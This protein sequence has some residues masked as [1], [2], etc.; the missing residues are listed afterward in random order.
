M[1]S[2]DE[3]GTVEPWQIDLTQYE[4]KDYDKEFD[5][6]QDVAPTEYLDSVI[7][8]RRNLIAELKKCYGLIDELLSG[9][10]LHHTVLEN[11]DY[12]DLMV[13]MGVF[14]RED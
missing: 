14:E 1:T 2:S 9:S 11:E 8:M 5:E 10:W 3:T 12:M 7:Q 13:R 6:M 4:E